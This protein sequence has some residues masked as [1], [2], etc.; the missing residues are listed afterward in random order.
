MRRPD[1]VLAALRLL[2]VLTT[3]TALAQRVEPAGLGSLHEDFGRLVTL[4]EWHASDP[5]ELDDPARPLG[6]GAVARVP[7]SQ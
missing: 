2:E 3:V 1:R 7:G 6:Y 4:P 5:K